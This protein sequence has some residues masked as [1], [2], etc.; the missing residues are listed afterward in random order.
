MENVMEERGEEE[1]RPRT[2]EG[3]QGERRGDKKRKGNGEDI[4][5]QMIE[6]HAKL[7]KTSCHPIFRSAGALP[8]KSPK[9]QSPIVLPQ[10][11]ARRAHF[12]GPY[13]RSS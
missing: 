10:E 2:D 9:V 11:T 5:T 4:G 1:P 7:A 6:F 3:T 12:V 8:R 13:R